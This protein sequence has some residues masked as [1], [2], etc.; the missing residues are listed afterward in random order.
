MQ[1][2]PVWLV[3]DQVVTIN[4]R[5]VQLTGEPHFVRDAGLLSSAVARPV[6]RWHYGDRDIVGLA[7]A[8]LLGIGRNHPF[9]QGNKRTA[10]SAAS[11]F[12]LFNGYTFVAPDGEP[13]GRF[14]E[15]SITG[16]IPEPV[17]L[18]TMQ[19]CVIT[20]LEWQA[21]KDSQD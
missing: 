7:G 8:L 11:V 21:Y 15:L 19:K 2:E 16:E 18:R 3:D 4:R 6:H 5:L 1:N 13:L 12:L 10:L 17:F 9:A 20:T 14:I